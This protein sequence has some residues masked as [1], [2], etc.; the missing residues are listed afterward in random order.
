MSIQTVGIVGAGTMGSGI[1][2]ACAV[3]GIQV[4]M[5]DISQAAV[6]KGLATIGKS[7]DR[8]LAKEKITDEQKDAALALIQTG[9]DYAA[10]K[11]AQLVIERPRK[12]TS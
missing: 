6:D 2:Q 4:V 12:T 10:L 8:L 9:T 11:S 3:K 5:I 1:A 7:L